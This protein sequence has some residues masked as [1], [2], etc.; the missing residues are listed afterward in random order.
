LLTLPIYL[1]SF[2][3]RGKIVSGCEAEKHHP[4]CPC[5]ACKHPRECNNC[6]T[7]LTVQHEI[8]KCIARE[9]LEIP[10]R[11]MGKDTTAVSIPCHNQEDKKVP[12][13]LAIMRQL[14]RR[15]GMIPT[16]E[17][18]LTIRRMGMFRG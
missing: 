11:E 13:I 7:P 4:S 12:F 10:P 18:V 15:E 1:L 6:K 14:K 9:I 17:D 8:P 2:M 3:E 16:R 5:L